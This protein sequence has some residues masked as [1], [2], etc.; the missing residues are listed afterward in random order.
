M[1]LL[2]IELRTSGRA[3][4]PLNHWA[5]STVVT[6]WILWHFFQPLKWLFIVYGI[7]HVIYVVRSFCIVYCDFFICVCVTNLDPWE[8]KE[9][10]KTYVRLLM[11]SWESLHLY[12]S[13]WLVYSDLFSLKKNNSSFVSGVL[14]LRWVCSCTLDVC[15]EENFENLPLCWNKIILYNIVYP[16]TCTLSAQTLSVG[17]MCVYHHSQLFAFIFLIR[18]LFHLHFQCYPKSP[19]PAPPPTP[20]SWP[21]CSPVLRQIKFARPMGLSFHWWPTR[22]SSDTYAAR[23]TSSGGGGVTR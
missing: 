19:P 3:V 23:D 2:G 1:R 10:L 12:S 8:E 6:S 7:S 11:S 13:G 16:Q 20:T 17:I 9:F 22:P 18:Y 15:V 14:V 21:W 4:S 5:V